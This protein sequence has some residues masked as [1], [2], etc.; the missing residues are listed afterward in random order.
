MLCRFATPTDLEVGDRVTLVRDP[1]YVGRIAVVEENR[2]S[3]MVQWDDCIG[4]DF[5]WSNKV[6]PIGETP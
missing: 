5:Q 1:D 2:L 3:V 6:A 4:L